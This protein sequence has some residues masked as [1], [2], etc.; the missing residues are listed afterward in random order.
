[1]RKKL[2]DWTKVLQLLKTSSGAKRI[3]DHDPEM[4]DNDILALQSGAGSDTQLEEAY[5][6]IGEYYSERQRWD[7][8]VKYYTLGRNLAKQM[9]CYYL[10]ENYDD[11][12]K[13]L[14]QLTE[15]S[16]LLPVN[17]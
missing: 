5:N 14:E 2:G 4:L 13:V 10:L 3:A 12:V 9:E 7:I 16:E 8:A 15:N 17:I 1:M 11:L 6:E